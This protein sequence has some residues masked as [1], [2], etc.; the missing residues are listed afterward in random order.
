[1]LTGL[2]NLS[3]KLGSRKEI[4]NNDNVGQNNGNNNNNNSSSNTNT[5]SVSS[6][7]PKSSNNS[8]NN[9]SANG[10]INC[11]LSEQTAVESSSSS[12][13]NFNGSQ[14]NSNAVAL[15]SPSSNNNNYDDVS[16]EPF[17]AAN[18][19]INMLNS[20]FNSNAL[21]NLGKVSLIFPALTG[22]LQSEVT[23]RGYANELKKLVK[24][25][26]VTL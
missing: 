6:N 15:L 2:Q 25:H 11:D 16:S 18:N 22:Y 9:R 23:V 10:Q 13:N 3:S 7:L 20:P 17:S 12:H 19:S 8:Q 24:Q 1:M 14:S 5:N 4:I 21:P 26:D